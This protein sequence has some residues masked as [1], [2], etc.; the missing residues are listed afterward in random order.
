M[1]PSSDRALR[2]MQHG[3]VCAA[4]FMIP[5]GQR[6]EWRR[7][8]QSELWH[9][10]HS[11]CAGGGLSWP[12]QREVT[13]FCLGSL[14]G[15]ALPA[16]R[17]APGPPAGA[18]HQRRGRTVRAAPVHPAGCLCH[19]CAASCPACS[20]SA[21]P[22]ASRS[23]PADPHPD[24]GIHRSVRR[25][26]FHRPSFKTGK[27]RGSATSTNLRSIAPCTRRPRC[28]PRPRP[29]ERDP[30]QSESLFAAWTADSNPSAAITEEH[31]RFPLVILSHD[32]WRRDFGADRDVAG[33]V[34]R[35]GD[36]NGAE[37]PA[38]CPTVMAIA[39]KSRRLAAGARLAT[40]SA[41]PPHARAI[42]SRTCRRWDKRRCMATA[43]PL[44]CAEPKTTTQYLRRLLRQPPPGAVGDFSIR[45]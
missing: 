15:C 33:R 12:A 31:W 2:A 17:I 8:W 42:W 26:P 27:A 20:R 9:V 39:G 45:S 14:P 11:L 30:C 37:L 43:L 34:I 16:P 10:R 40:D 29:M 23:I 32:A 36:R 41:S 44:Q 13:A 38:S 6:A 1:T 3:M 25:P 18:P 24:L 35:L 22:R 5:A 28:L 19:P 7:E 21:I 4:S